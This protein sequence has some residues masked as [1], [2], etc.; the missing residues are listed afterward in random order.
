MPISKSERLR[1]AYE[2]K[3]G[4]NLVSKL[5]DS[6]IKLISKYYNSLSDSEQSNIDSKILQGYS[7]TDLHEMARGFIEEEEDDEQIPEGLDDLLSGIR[8]PEAKVTKMT[9]SALVA[10]GGSSGQKVDGK[11]FFG[12]SKYQK[13]ID[14]LTSSGT[15]DGEPLSP[16]ERKEGFKKREDKIGFESFVKKILAKKESAVITEEKKKLTDSKVGGS[17][18]VR[19]QKIDPKKVVP[20]PVGKASEETQENLDEILGKIDSILET[21]KNEEK[22]KKK[23]DAENRR[24]KE[25]KKRNKKEEKLESSIFKGLAKGVDKVLK[26]VKSIF[27]KIFDFFTAIFFARIVTKIFD[28]LGDKENQQKLKSLIRF[29]SD[30]WPVI[31]GA[32]LL[33]GTKFG[34]LIR[35]I[36]KWAVQIAKFAIPKLLRFIAK[37]PRTAILLAGAG[38]LGARILTN[39]EAGGEEESSSEEE[40]SQFQADQEAAKQSEGVTPSAQEPME[41]AKGGSVPGSGNRDSVPAML[42]P[43]EFVMS[44]GAVAKYGTN[45]LA[46]MNSM[47][48]GTNI[49]SI[50]SG[51]M[52]FQGGGK[53]PSG[54]EESTREQRGPMDWVRNI[55][56]GGKTA[57]RTVDDKSKKGETK[58]G[59]SRNAKALLNTIRWAEGTL[60]PGGYNTWFGGRTDMDL[61][62]MTI[63]EVVA[64]QK[65]RL[66]S[67][68]ATYGKY[69]S[70]AVGAYQM[71]TP[72]TFAKRAGFDPA[73]TKFTPEVQD[74][75][76]IAGYMMGQARMTQAEIDAPINKAQIAKMAP[77]WASLPMMNGRSRY[78]QPV[79]KY[80]DL[81]NVYDKNLKGLDSNSYS[82]STTIASSGSGGGGTGGGGGSGGG[83][84]QET[85]LVYDAA[86]NSYTI[87]GESGDEKVKSYDW[88]EMRKYLGVSTSSEPIGKSGAAAVAKSP[89]MPK[90]ESGQSASSK[91]SSV[92]KS[93]RPSAVSSYG[94]LQ[95]MS[96]GGATPLGRSADSTQKA[97]TDIPFINSMA[98]ASTRKIKTLGIMI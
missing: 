45:T 3:L 89:S 54:D 58:G 43:G 42:T 68:E 14:E 34:K 70:A 11:K 37:N 53:V 95:Q 27:R 40:T 75:M 81:V 30:F 9:S 84:G 90:I 85:K 62:K 21:I 7:G 31:A 8:A 6:Q 33:F 35:T 83:G 73:S 29:L 51:V 13:Y 24:E 74:K 71:M 25:K 67:G 19:S 26:P 78:G 94:Q 76:A 60:K 41:F 86:S 61:T 38:Y 56:S 57:K 69:T 5:S 2:S 10:V 12:E 16:S 15:I 28:W 98:M 23:R 96:S 22:T 36:G 44:K 66:K 79:K 46:A 64:E 17:L 32:Y 1:K 59:I 91:A 18:V 48:G 47:G 65:R 63:N 88:D 20:E 82:T 72:E 92:S 97:R 77:V 55:F 4:K 49:P 80:Q 52:G 93:S 87:K 50:S 39:K